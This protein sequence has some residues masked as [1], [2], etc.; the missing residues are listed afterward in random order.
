M[1]TFF[2]HFMVRPKDF[3]M[4]RHSAMGAGEGAGSWHGDKGNDLFDTKQQMNTV[5]HGIPTGLPPE[6]T[7]QNHQTA[8]V[9]DLRC[10]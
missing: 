10:N 3:D 8:E 4:R 9:K 6:S 1:K 7:T 5:I 2:L